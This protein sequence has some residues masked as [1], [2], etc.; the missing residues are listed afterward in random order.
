M[1]HSRW[2]ISISW[3]SKKWM[4]ERR[5]YQSWFWLLLPVY[6]KLIFDL[7]S[8]A[9]IQSQQMDDLNL[10]LVFFFLL[11]NFKIGDATI[12]IEFRLQMERDIFKHPWI[13]HAEWGRHDAYIP[14]NLCYDM[15]AWRRGSYS[16]VEERR[17]VHRW[18]VS[19]AIMFLY[20]LGRYMDRLE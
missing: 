11:L 19:G 17:A 14:T 3:M 18:H 7:F 10:R 15:S 9:Q 2:A 20:I 6:I 16:W 4:T 1:I 8:V 5:V 13:E 12:W